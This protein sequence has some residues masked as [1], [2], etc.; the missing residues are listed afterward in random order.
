MVQRDAVETRVVLVGSLDTKAAEYDLLRSELERAGVGTVLVDV[1]VLGTPGIR[2]D[3]S[4]EEVARAAGANL[5]SLAAHGDR[6]EAVATMARGAAH[7]LT[8][9]RQSDRVDG[10]MVA[11]G[12]N[13]G[14]T[15]SALASQLPFGAPK[16]LLSTIVIGQTRPYA[17]IADATMINP[18][19][20]IA[21][22]NSLSWRSLVNAAGAMVGMLATQSRTPPV[23]AGRVVAAT[24]LGVTTTG[25]TAMRERLE[26]LGYEVLIFHANGVGGEAM[27][28]LIA[29]GVI[30]GVADLTTAE[31]ADEVV[32]GA[33]PAGPARLT[34]ATRAGIPQ[35][36][37]LGGLDI[38]KFGAPETVPERFADRLLYR[39]NAAVTLMRTSVEEARAIGARVGHALAGATPGTARVLVP[40]R[41]F[42]SMSTP[43]E[44]VSS[45]DADRAL[46]DAL[47][48]SRPTNVPV[49][50]V[51]QDCNS[52]AFA[53]RVAESLHELMTTRHAAETERTS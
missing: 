30:A 48:D 12:S 44:R 3:V 20:D 6:G 43:G 4:S 10:L 45:E 52:P 47:A 40:E 28:H 32:G 51:D 29:Q 25:A 5:A 35:V 23:S 34:A 2:P 50:A 33:Y 11:G 31:I 15:F 22:L 36:V 53:H 21:G 39:H 24:M 26:E 18:V 46:V 41:G 8:R 13:A 37:S 16:V 38:V 17:G 9:L 1:G 49:D 19:V 42:S 27:E 14:T 7:I